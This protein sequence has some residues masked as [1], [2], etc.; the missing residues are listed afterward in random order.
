[1]GGTRLSLLLL[2]IVAGGCSANGGDEQQYE[3][4]EHGYVLYCPCMGELQFWRLLP[5]NYRAWASDREHLDK[6]LVVTQ[7]SN[8]NFISCQLMS[9]E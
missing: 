8:K 5:H 2:A 4:D 9:R 1:M 7:F 6:E 3:W